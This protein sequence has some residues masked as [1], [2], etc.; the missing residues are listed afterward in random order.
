MESDQIKAI[1]ARGLV[2]DRSAMVILNLNGK[3]HS[4][5]DPGSG[6]D[7]RLE[8]LSPERTASRRVQEARA[9][10]DE[11]RLAQRKYHK[12]SRQAD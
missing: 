6:A 7:L 10:Q 1:R 2:L 9:D 12:G 3:P 11:T 4:S 5:V 8:T